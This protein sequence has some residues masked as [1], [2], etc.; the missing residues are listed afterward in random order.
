MI[1]IFQSEWKEKEALR[2]RKEETAL[3]RQI[4]QAERERP[5]Q[6]TLAQMSETLAKL[7]VQLTLATMAP[8]PPEK[9]SNTR[10]QQTGG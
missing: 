10:P 1:A 6:A 8:V 7:Q 4:E 3:Q 5:Q 9:R 2:D